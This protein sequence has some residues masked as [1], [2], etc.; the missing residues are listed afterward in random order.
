M[1]A[2]FRINLIKLTQKYANIFGSLLSTGIPANIKK[3]IFDYF[4][5]ASKQ[6][7]SIQKVERDLNGNIIYED[8]LDENGKK[9]KRKKPLLIFTKSITYL[10]KQWLKN[11]ES[12]IRSSCRRNKYGTP[13]VSYSGF[14]LCKPSWCVHR[15]YI[16]LMDCDECFQF[17]WIR[18]ALDAHLQ[19]NHDSNCS[20]CDL[21]H[22]L[23]T[24]TFD[25]LDDAH[26][27]LEYAS[28]LDEYCTLPS[29][30][31]VRGEC[32][33]C[34]TNKYDIILENDQSPGDIIIRYKQL[35]E[36][37]GKNKSQKHT[38]SKVERLVPIKWNDLKGLY[39]QKLKRFLLH[40]FEVKQQL[41]A[42]RY[43]TK[44]L[45]RGQLFVS[46]DFISNIKC[47][48]SIFPNSRTPL[49]MQVFYFYVFFFSVFIVS[50]QT[51]LYVIYEVDIIDGK[52]IENVY[53]YISD[54]S[55]K[56]AC[57]AL[58]FLD[59]YIKRRKI[60]YFRT[61]CTGLQ[62]VIVFGDRGSGDQW[63]ADWLGHSVEISFKH[64]VQIVT[65]TLPGGHNKWLHDAF[66]NIAK[67]AAL[68]GFNGDIVVLDLNDSPAEKI[69]EWLN[70]EYSVSYDGVKKFHYVYVP[71]EDVPPRYSNIDTLKIGKKGV[72]SFYCARSDSTGHLLFRYGSCF[73]DHCIASKFK[74]NCA[75]SNK[76]GGWIKCNGIKSKQARQKKDAN[77]AST[78]ENNSKVRE[79]FTCIDGKYKKPNSW[80]VP[81]LK[82]LCRKHNV[83]LR[84]SDR[85]ADII[86]KLIAKAAQ[87]NVLISSNHNNRSN[88][89]RNN[90]QQ[91]RNYDR[92]RANTNLNSN[93]NIRRQQNVHHNVDNIHIRRNTNRRSRPSDTGY[94]SFIRPPS[95]QRRRLN[96]SSIN[97]KQNISRQRSPSP[98]IPP[99][100]PP[101]NNT[102]LPPPPP[103]I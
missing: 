4:I 26:C 29:L 96:S 76:V 9:I 85:K 51:K 2:Y 64:N 70:A 99:P 90:N 21:C 23:E 12:L 63:G 86:A 27:E 101:S 33:Q 44:N 48:S 87:H 39:K 10:H 32:K 56:G 30:N 20:G 40:N 47:T 50:E 62:T 11:N 94:N 49:E 22:L 102:F 43:I 91:S 15:T 7:P 74:V 18:E 78:N 66:G 37:K 77:N 71:A 97:N 8:E 5:D 3:H 75:M 14:K 28:Y 69:C 92:N 68:R 58:V 13:S 82:T 84:S 46:V 67:N 17:Q 95:Q 89:N 60:G 98:Y 83:F 100:K 80:T 42:R 41:Y 79:L 6:H 54:E 19:K 57:S 55:K 93:K 24:D 88:H 52:K 16:C 53:F 72:K 34:E 36:L 103:L 1:F 38:R 61:H 35:V 59:D 81:E 65:N 31:C 45:R 73:C 25:L